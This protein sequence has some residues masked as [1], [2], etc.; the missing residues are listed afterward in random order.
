MITAVNRFIKS[1][2]K[3]VEKESSDVDTVGSNNV[4]SEIVG[5]NPSIG[6]KLR[7]QLPTH[8]TIFG[9]IRKSVIARHPRDIQ[10]R[11]GGDATALL[12]DRL[13]SELMPR[14]T[15]VG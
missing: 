12:P 10:R 9:V 14:L 13:C 11:G 6:W 5:K 7:C 2:F 8:A 3:I 1:I 4:T 15:A